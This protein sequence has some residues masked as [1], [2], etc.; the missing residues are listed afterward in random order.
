MLASCIMPTRSRPELSRLAV[1]CFLSQTYSP[2]ELVIVDDADDRSFPNGISI[3]NVVYECLPVRLQIGGKR[4]HCCRRAMGDVIVHWDSDDWN[5]PERIEDQVTRLLE[6]G[7]EMT[8]YTTMQFTD[9]K[10]WWEY[11]GAGNYVL[12]TSFCYRRSVWERRQFPDVIL[13]EDLVFQQG[14]DIA[15]ALPRGLMWARNHNG[16][17]GRRNMKAPQWRELQPEEFPIC[18]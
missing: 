7:K 3:P 1:E 5:A 11:I 14:V 18:V 6:T 16:N 4:N 15:Y 8:G 10:L 13:G 9:G 12:G 17:C 2:R